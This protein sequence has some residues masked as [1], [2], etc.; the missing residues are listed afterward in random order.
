MYIFVLQ[1]Q[2]FLYLFSRIKNLTQVV[3]FLFY[4]SKMFYASAIS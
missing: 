1:K 4:F 2:I 3:R